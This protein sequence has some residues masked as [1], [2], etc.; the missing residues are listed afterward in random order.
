MANKK[1]M[2][3]DKLLSAL[4]K[5]FEGSLLSFKI[6]PLV[7]QRTLITMDVSLIENKFIKENG[8]LSFKDEYAESVQ[9]VCTSLGYKNVTFNNTKTTFWVTAKHP[10]IIK[11]NI[12]VKNI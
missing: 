7:P 3:A 12:K 11:Y 4:R 5:E 1:Q 10:Q 2:E 6:R 8:W 9:R